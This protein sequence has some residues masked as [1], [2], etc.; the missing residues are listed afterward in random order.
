MLERMGVN[1]LEELSYRVE[2]QGMPPVYVHDF[3]MNHPGDLQF[4][5]AQVKPK[6]EEAFARAWRGEV[7]NDDFNRLVLLAN[8]GWREVTILRAYSKY[9]RQTG[10]TF[11]QAYVEQALANNAAIARQLIELFLTRFDPANAADTGIKAK[12]WTVQ[13]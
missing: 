10:F 7:E 3:G 12:A 1:V 5:V 4:E 8:L 9:L 6:F 13:I 2:P 11:R